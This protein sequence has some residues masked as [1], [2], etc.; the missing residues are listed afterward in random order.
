MTSGGANASIACSVILPAESLESKYDTVSNPAWEQKELKWSATPLNNS[1][2]TPISFSDN[3]LN[4][5]LI[6]APP[7]NT[8][9]NCSFLLSHS[10]NNDNE[11]SV[12]SLAHVSLVTVTMN[13]VWIVGGVDL[14]VVCSI[15]NTYLR[16]SDPKFTWGETDYTETSAGA[17]GLAISNVFVNGQKIIRLSIPKSKMNS[18]SLATGFKCS[19][20]INASPIFTISA[21]GLLLLR[22][23]FLVHRPMFT[24]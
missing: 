2:T 6:G 15:S 22:D 11:L 14:I 19:A 24:K 7:F 10:D 1:E 16:V 3:T 20:V 18:G 8:S 21:S 4:F 12:W 23:R 13:Q 5:T 9:W 17:A